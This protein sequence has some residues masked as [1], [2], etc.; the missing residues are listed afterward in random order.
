VDFVIVYILCIASAACRS[1]LGLGAGEKNSL[2]VNLV[3]L[4]PT[5]GGSALC[6]DSFFP[7][8]GVGFDAW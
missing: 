7:L 5:A 3:N 2:V 4:K 6:G 8:V 1:G